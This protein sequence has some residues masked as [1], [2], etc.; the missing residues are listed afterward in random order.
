MLPSP[1]PIISWFYFSVCFYFSALP[2]FALFYFASFVTLA[3]TSFLCQEASRTGFVFFFIRYVCGDTLHPY[4]FW[5]IHLPMLPVHMYT[6]M[7]D[8]IQNN[9]LFDTR[10]SCRTHENITQCDARH[11]KMNN[12]TYSHQHTHLGCL[13]SWWSNRKRKRERNGV[14]RKLFA[15]YAL[16]I[17]PKQIPD[18]LS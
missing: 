17:G 14:R 3:V 13:T 10:R 7:V 4:I 6:Y 15:L 1:L 18:Y 16:T 8:T 5:F 11:A 12:V 2:S 9:I